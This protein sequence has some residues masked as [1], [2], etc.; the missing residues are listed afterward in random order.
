M[1]G[2]G[3]GR[4]LEAYPLLP[5]LPKSK[6]ARGN[7]WGSGVAAS[8]GREQILHLLL[9]AERAGWFGFIES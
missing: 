8:I 4:D 7:W 2:L 9:G 6:A 3:A 1:E 5:V